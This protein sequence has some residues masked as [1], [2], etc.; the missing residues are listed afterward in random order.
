MKQSDIS[1]FAIAD[2]DFVFRKLAVS[3]ICESLQRKV[4]FC[5]SD[6]KELLHLLQ[7][8]KPDLLIIDLYMPIIS[9]IEA[10]QLIRKKDVN[11]KIIACSSIFQEELIAHLKDLK[12]N[13]YCQRVPTVVK[14]VYEIVNNG[15]SFYDAEYF[16][17]WR[18]YP[19]TLQEEDKAHQSKVSSTLKAIEIKLILATCTGKH[20][21]EIA[22]E[23]NLSHR[24][25]DTY[26]GNLL[27]KF[28]LKNKSELVSFAL[29]N[30][31]CKQ[32]C[33]NSL[34][35]LCELKTPFSKKTKE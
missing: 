11:I 31:I 6:G 29:S 1:L 3:A 22:K 30:G 26:I 13:G 2:D 20:N 32:L 19:A 18:T 4:S 23:L 12:I 27:A 17:R 24:T 8:H 28:H 34:N 5:A 10:I 15:N 9:G 7:T 35:G 25:I 14:D 33:E 16:D 21:K